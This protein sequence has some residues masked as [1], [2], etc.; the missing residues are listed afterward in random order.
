MS[1]H[2]LHRWLA[3]ETGVLLAVLLALVALVGTL[4]PVTALLVG[5]VAYTSALVGGRAPDADAGQSGLDET[6]R[7]GPY[8]YLVALGRFL[9]TVVALLAALALAGEGPVVAGGLAGVAVLAVALGV[10]RALPDLLSR[11]LPRRGLPVELP[12]WVLASLGGMVAARQ[13]LLGFDATAVAVQ[14][15]P[16]AVGVPI[17]VGVVARVPLDAARRTLHRYAPAPVERRVLRREL[18][19][20]GSRALDRVPLLLRFAFDRRLGWR[21]RLAVLL[22]VAAPVV[23]VVVVWLA[24]YYLLFVPLVG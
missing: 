18:G 10:V 2:E 13:V 16:L 7:S 21:G 23:T 11:F 22:A 6:Y 4:E 5:A 8:R 19:P 12:F 9:V 14:Y 17:V 24:L 3:R 1:G 20:T 15:L